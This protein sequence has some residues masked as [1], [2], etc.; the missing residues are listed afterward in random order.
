MRDFNLETFKGNSLF[1]RQQ[2]SM[3]PG[4]GSRER[5]SWSALSLVVSSI[6]MTIMTM[7]RMARIMNLMMSKEW[8]L[9]GLVFGGPTQVKILHWSDKDD[10]K[11]NM[12]MIKMMSKTEA[13]L[14]MV[15]LVFVA[16]GVITSLMVRKSW[17]SPLLNSIKFKE[18]SPVSFQGCSIGCDYCLTDPMHPANN[19]SIP[20]NVSMGDIPFQS[21]IFSLMGLLMCRGVIFFSGNYRKPTSCRQSRLPQILL[22]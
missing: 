11:M 5:R 17:I 16:T 12:A 14:V 9:V 15:S 6:K 18:V 19:G 22:R 1:L 3:W 21:V 2:W 10:I 4:S 7:I 8:A 13:M 20:T